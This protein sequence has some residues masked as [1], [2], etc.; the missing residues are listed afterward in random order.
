MKHN[1][2]LIACTA[3]QWRRHGD[4]VRVEPL[5]RMS[6]VLRSCLICGRKMEEHGWIDGVGVIH[7]G[8]WI[9]EIGQQTLVL[10]PSTYEILLERVK[11]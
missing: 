6:S 3:N 2:K 10:R 8:D 7:P 9:V 1:T 4:S 11:P 5:V